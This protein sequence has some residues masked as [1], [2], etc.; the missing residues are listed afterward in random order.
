MIL[1]LSINLLERLGLI[2]MF[3][4]FISRTKFFKNY[5]LKIK[6]TFKEN[7]IFAILWGFMGILMTMLGTPVSGGIANS[8]TI[9][10]VVSGLLG[11]PVVGAV[12]GLI[13]GIH[14]AFFATGGDLT[15]ISCGISTLLGGIIAGY[16][17]EYIE[18]KDK[19]W[20]YG[21]FVGLVVEILQMIIILIIAKPY[22][23]ALKLVKI[24][25]IPM[26][27]LNALGIGLF[28]LFIQQIIMENE[29]AAALKAQVSLEIANLTL[30]Y[31]RTGLNEL[32]AEKAANIIKNITKYAAVS[33][34]D[35]EKVLA[36]I[37]LGAD[38]HKAGGDIWTNITRKCIETGE[39]KF[40]VRKN[41]I[42]CENTECSLKSVIVAPLKMNDS[43]IGVLKIYKNKENAILKSDIELLKGLG[44]LF[45]TQIELGNIETQKQLREQAELKA[46]RAQIK[47]HFLFNSLNAIMSITRTNPEEA[48][49]LLQE[50]S[51]F[52]RTSFKNSDPFIPIE[53]EIR[54]IEAY[55]SIEKARFPDK[56]FIEYDIDHNINM[57]IPPLIFQPLVENA[58]KHGIRNKNGK[59]LVKICINKQENLMKFKVEDDGIGMEN[60]EIMNNNSADRGVGLINVISRLKSIYN[61]ELKITTNKNVGTTITFEIPMNGGRL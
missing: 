51:I 45:S 28:F 39:I 48:R 47:P 58:V 53:E 10:I 34:T 26:T 40:A 15:S 57:M 18:S 54:Y 56:L 49:R 31:F 6:Y 43:V 11:G 16:A 52:L 17:K 61:E 38:H 36:H 25:F 60:I 2:I 3:A 12:S 4:F 29:N 14:R 50:L 1:T 19:K 30:P 23:E 55:L 20:I 22:Y 35:T 32:T 27:F 46:L 33:I 44:N 59:G 7:I 37:G 24:I 8:R 13:A 9:P 42:G 21:I 41:Q 5:V